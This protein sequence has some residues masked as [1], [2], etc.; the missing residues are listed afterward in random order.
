[1]SWRAL[2][3]LEKFRA[4]ELWPGQTVP[5][6][7]HRMNRKISK[8]RRPL[9]RSYFKIWRQILVDRG[10]SVTVDLLSLLPQNLIWAYMYLIVHQETRMLNMNEYA[11]IA[12]LNIYKAID[13]IKH[14]MVSLWK[15]LQIWLL[16]YRLIIFIGTYAFDRIEV[17]NM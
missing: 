10:L 17:C 7:W 12:S 1:M 8:A 2:V 13:S 6:N 4:K 16:A 15:S 11:T 3:R 14:I 9:E 5:M